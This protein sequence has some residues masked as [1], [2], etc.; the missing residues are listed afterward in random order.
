MV[1]SNHSV[2]GEGLRLYTNGLGRFVKQRLEAT[3]GDTWWE[4]GVIKTRSYERWRQ[5]EREM[6]KDPSANKVTFLDPGTF[7]DIINHNHAI[8][9]DIFPNRREV[10][11][12]LVQV[13]E[14]RNRWA[15]S[16]ASSDL[17]EDDVVLTLMAMEKLLSDAGLSEVTEVRKL[18]QQVMRIPEPQPPKPV[19][20]HDVKPESKIYNREPESQ[21]RVT[22]AEVVRQEVIDHWFTPARSRGEREVMVA[23]RDINKRL[24]WS[25]RYPSI[26]SAL[27]DRS[28]ELSRRANVELIRSTHPNPSSTTEFI[29]RLL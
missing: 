1:Q 18:R 7:V 26:C 22:L 20:S 25:Q 24:R 29:Y 14:A 4:E 21:P 3:F 23:A 2:L 16:L 5:L 8:F 11:A 13:S 19:V 12:L 9:R 10:R 28:G 27:S 6:A 17:A 15:H